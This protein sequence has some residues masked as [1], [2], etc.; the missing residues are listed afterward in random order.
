MASIGHSGMTTEQL[1]E[2]IE[3]AVKGVD[4]MRT[5]SPLVLSCV[6]LLSSVTWGF[7][8]LLFR[9]IRE[10]VVLVVAVIDTER[11]GSRFEPPFST[12]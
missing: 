7:K 2:N 10:C 4:E 5:V 3:S 1:T 6:C 8:P 12:A 9:E 11:K